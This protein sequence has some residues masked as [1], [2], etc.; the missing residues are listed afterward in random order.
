MERWIRRG[1]TSGFWVSQDFTGKIWRYF[2]EISANLEPI[3]MVLPRSTK[4]ISNRVP[5]GPSWSHQFPK[6]FASCV[7]STG[8]KGK[9]HHDHQHIQHDTVSHPLRCEPW[10][11][12][13]M[14]PP[15]HTGA[16]GLF[17]G[18]KNASWYWVWYWFESSNWQLLDLENVYETVQLYYLVRN[19]ASANFTLLNFLG[20]K[21]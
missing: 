15:H 9:A 1:F 8:K 21:Q 13:T 16:L 10:H 11:Y 12:E 19:Y 3:A 2:L 5:H 14:R 17:F 7:Q 4:T 20:F 6:Q 18:S